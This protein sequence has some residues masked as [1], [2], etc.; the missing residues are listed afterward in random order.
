MTAT[1][2]YRIRKS[3]RRICIHRLPT[4]LHRAWEEESGMRLSAREAADDIQEWDVIEQEQFAAAIARDHISFAALFTGTPWTEQ[5]PTFDP[6]ATTWGT[7]E[8]V[9]DGE[10]WSERIWGSALGRVPH[11]STRRESD[12]MGFPEWAT[13]E[14]D[15]RRHRYS[16]NPTCGG[17]T[18]QE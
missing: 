5:G 2:Q 6:P 11:S 12:T 7:T 9:P 4:A 3:G 13:G 15:L 14:C 1:R 16:T 18:A 10:A 17:S 8:W